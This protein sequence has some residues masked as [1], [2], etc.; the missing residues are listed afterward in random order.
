MNLFLNSFFC[1]V[2]CV[3]F[4]CLFL[5]LGIVVVFVIVIKGEGIFYGLGK[6]FYVF[7]FS[8]LFVMILYMNV[9]FGILNMLYMIVGVYCKKVNFFLVVKILFICI[10]FNLIGGVLFGFLVLFMVLF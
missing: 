4:V 6:M 8:W 3:M 7:M 5:M 1:Y 10:L 2:V 9:E